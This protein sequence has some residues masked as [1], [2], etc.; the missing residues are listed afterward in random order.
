LNLEMRTEFHRVVSRRLKKGAVEWTF[1]AE[2]SFQAAVAE[3]DI[4]LH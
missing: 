4:L 3:L 1:L 2:T